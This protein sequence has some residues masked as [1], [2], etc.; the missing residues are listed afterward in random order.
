MLLPLRTHVHCD[1]IGQRTETV[2]GTS[3][4]LENRYSQ[5]HS[6][7]PKAIHEAGIKY[8]TQTP[9]TELKRII[10]LNIKG[11]VL[12]LLENLYDL[13]LGFLDM[14]AKVPSHKSKTVS[15]NQKCWTSLTVRSCGE[16]AWLPAVSTAQLMQ[17][18]MA[19]ADGAKDGGKQC[20]HSWRPNTGNW[21]SLIEPSHCTPSHFAREHASTPPVC[22]Q[23]LPSQ[24]TPAGN[25]SAVLQW[26]K[27]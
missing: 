27:D 25:S 18:P 1:F 6:V 26:R 24:L 16:H 21:R 11:K 17:T 19:P 14:T 10:T 23:V 7:F 2:N 13:S 9:T 12:K 4:S 20:Q 15:R 3:T 8:Q 22:S 5:P